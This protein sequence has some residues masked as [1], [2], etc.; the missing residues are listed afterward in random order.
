[1]AAKKKKDEAKAAPAVKSPLAPVA[2][3]RLDP[4]IVIYGVLD[5]AML[6][7]YLYLILF[8]AK[9]RNPWAQSIMLMIPAFT[10]MMGV[11]TLAGALSRIA[12]P[13]LAKVGWWLAILG[14]AGMLIFMVIVLALLLSSAAFLS[15]VY[16]AFGKGAAA[17]IMGA[18]ALIFE[19]VGILPT[20]Q[21]K[22]LM[23]RAGRR[24]F[25]LEPLFAA[26]G[27]PRKAKA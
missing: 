4:R 23:T 27:S 16:G 25:G 5:A 7:L 6:A 11:G 20:L 19:L 10:V 8:A 24:S 17:G 18:M 26:P 3:R 21:A 2:K 1:M 15:G 14:A 13:G 12:A 9:N 22:F